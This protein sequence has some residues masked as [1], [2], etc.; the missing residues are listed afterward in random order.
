MKSSK[1]NLFNEKD[2]VKL[3][4][5]YR[6]MTVEETKN[7]QELREGARFSKSQAHRC[8]QYLNYPSYKP[9]SLIDFLELTSN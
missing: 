1:D 5:F 3:P 2:L 4:I 6:F 9:I 8:N 7:I